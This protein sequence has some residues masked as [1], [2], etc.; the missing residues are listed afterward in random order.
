MIDF[1]ELDELDANV[2]LRHVFGDADDGRDVRASV[3]RQIVERLKHEDV[4]GFNARDPFAC[5]DEP[6]RVLAESEVNSP[7]ARRTTLVVLVPFREEP[8]GQRSWQLERFVAHFDSVVAASLPEGVEL[9]VVILEQ[10]PRGNFNRGKLLNVGV[11][12]CHAYTDGDVLVCTHDVD[13]LPEP[14]LLPFY[15]HSQL[16]ECVHPGWV[17][18]KYD[19]K[20]FFG[21]VCC[22]SLA[23]FLCSGGFPNEFWGWGR[24]DDVLHGRLRLAGVRV[25]VPAVSSGMISLDDRHA[26][27]RV[28]ER[29]SAASPRWRSENRVFRE[30]FLGQDTIYDPP[31]F[32]VLEHSDGG[33]FWHL[34]LDL[35]PG[36]SQ[37]AASTSSVVPAILRRCSA[38]C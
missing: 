2:R 31:S 5:A 38:T 10:G 1:D 11:R 15:C 16:R 4:D 37:A 28:G 17:G 13:M 30:H 24:E 14:S 9:K 7:R 36:P 32:V 34:L 35:Q 25:C 18:R 29:R 23:D 8:S 21:G 27:D 6:R 3:F 33:R 26:P 19:Y 22:V 12:W 20:H